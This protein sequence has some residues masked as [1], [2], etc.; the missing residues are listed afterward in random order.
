V[1]VT[2]P[3]TG[4][5][6]RAAPRTGTHEIDE[7]TAIGTM[8]M[9]SLISAQLRLSTK[10]ILTVLGVLA[11][12]PLLFAA[13]PATRTFSVFGVPLPWLVLGVLAYPTIYGA[14]RYYIRQ[15][16]RIEAS[17]VELVAR[18]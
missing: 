17:F 7:Q 5:P 8:Y 18:R 10:V 13:V 6:R 9:D 4:T 11:S 14:A 1:R 12:L 3:R 16:E 2:S 15:A